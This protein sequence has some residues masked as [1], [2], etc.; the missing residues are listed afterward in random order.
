VAV[1]VIT[2]DEG[3]RLFMAAALEASRWKPHFAKDGSEA[4][5]LLAAQFIPVV[6]MDGDA[7]APSWRELL[8]QMPGAEASPGP[9]FIV[10]SRLADDRLW[11][12]VLNLGGYDLLPKPLDADEVTRVVRSAL[13]ERS[14]T[15]VPAR[16]ADIQEQCAWNGC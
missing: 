6:I 14:V 4:R 7:Q 15:R 11:A 3:D 2:T 5:A 8:E 1:L 9:K 10:V 13:S 16:P 12:E